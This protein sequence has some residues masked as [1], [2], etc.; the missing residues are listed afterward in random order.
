MGTLAEAEDVL[1]DN[2]LQRAVREADSIADPLVK[3]DIFREIAWTK[4]VL[5]HRKSALQMW[6]K[7]R[8]IL[9]DLPA[10]V[11]KFSPHPLVRLAENQFQAGDKKA[12]LET[13]RQAIRVEMR[14][15]RYSWMYADINYGFP[16]LVEA[17]QSAAALAILKDLNELL[18][19]PETRE[20]IKNSRLMMPASGEATALA[21]LDKASTHAGL[22]AKAGDYAGALRLLK[23]ADSFKKEGGEPSAVDA[24]SNILYQTA[25]PTRERPGFEP[26]VKLGVEVIPREI[27]GMSKN[28]YL[29]ALAVG[30][31][32][33]GWFDDALKTIGEID[34]SLSVPTPGL[35]VSGVVADAYGWVV[36]EQAKAGDRA[37]VWKTA[38]AMVKLYREKS[39][40]DWKPFPSAPPHLDR[41]ARALAKV[42]DFKHALGLGESLQKG[43]ELDVYT[44]ISIADLQAAGGFAA[45]A[46]ATIEKALK[47]AGDQKAM[48]YPAY[49]ALLASLGKT[50]EALHALNAFPTNTYG[51]VTVS[52]EIA[53]NGDS[54]TAL[55][56]VDLAPNAASRV[57]VL[58]ATAK[59]LSIERKRNPKP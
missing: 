3:G 17:D 6:A 30:Q 21:V 10:D 48:E 31:A 56:L 41:A 50:K 25:V 15:G 14:Q 32:K 2:L 51:L 42:G 58:L 7:A 45:D 22:L 19:K 49:P 27:K 44:L 16:L 35:I 39:P 33:M 46:R 54:K 23:D 52:T 37:G 47:L 59:A 18:K 36:K 34:L 24:L 40:D 26:L 9:E 5:G 20:Q 29:R 12:A 11:V 13:F 38:Q 8:T 57:S 28:T 1:I 55:D 4:V 53:L 43:L